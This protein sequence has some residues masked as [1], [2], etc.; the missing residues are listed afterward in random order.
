[1]PVCILEADDGASWVAVHA[2][3]GELIAA[4]VPLPAARI[5]TDLAFAA[6]VT[7]IAGGLLSFLIRL[8]VE[9]GAGVVYT[10]LAPRYDVLLDWP[11]V[12]IAV[13]GGA[14]L[15]LYAFRVARLALPDATAQLTSQR[16]R[17]PNDGALG[18]VLLPVA[19]LSLLVFG[20]NAWNIS[21][22]ASVGTA[23]GMRL[24]V[25][26]G[27]AMLVAAYRFRR[28]TRP[29]EWSA[30]ER[31]EIE[32]GTASDLV[33][34]SV[35]V[36]LVTLFVGFSTNTFANFGL[37]ERLASLNDGFV[38][39]L[40][41]FEAH[42]FSVA[43]ILAV[44][45]ARL[46]T[47]ARTTVTVG[48]LAGYLASILAGPV[49]KA[50]VVLVAVFAVT[51]IQG[52]RERRAGAAADAILVAVEFEVLATLGRLSGAA[53]GALVWRSSWG[54]G[55]GATIV[56]VVVV[57]AGVAFHRSAR[58]AGRLDTVAQA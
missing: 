52:R 46:P 3:R 21:S 33:A 25:L 38:V 6:L 26:L 30:P 57:T 42:A 7:F 23:L 15:V 39:P 5:A 17:F 43:G 36:L 1:M 19:W 41:V 54:V 20:Y 44:A 56:E 27:V 49:G 24:T 29:G 2:D 45:S 48:M 34:L 12:A 18:R 10:R 14:L 47:E 22:T 35:R 55:L 28:Q 4:D 9:A 32:P 50:V 53:V 51:L 58:A 11:Y 40:G 16:L 8:L 31:P 37:M 13:V